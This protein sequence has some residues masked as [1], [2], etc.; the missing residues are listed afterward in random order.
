MDFLE[1][2]IDYIE[3]SLSLK[4][5][6]KVGKLG[7]ETESIAIVP[8]PSSMVNR[9]MDKERLREYSFQVLTK[10][11]NQI[12]ASKVLKDITGLL[13]GINDDEIKSNNNSFRLI[14]CEVYVL[15]N[16]VE[17]T[18]HKEYIYTA[19]FTAEIQGGI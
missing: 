9:F 12:E 4:D 10:N 1:R 16:Y 15:P 5:A 6:I 19:M 13:D 17:M 18:N 3:D 7:P 2:L 11:R 14:K 8:T